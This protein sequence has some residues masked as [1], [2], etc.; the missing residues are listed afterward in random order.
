MIELKNISK[1]FQTPRGTKSVLSDF[2]LTVNDGTF[3]GISGE[4][5]AGKSTL[6]SIIIGLQ[7]PSSG[8]VLID[9][10]DIFSLSDKEL[11]A[12]RNENIGFVSQEQSFLENLTVLEN[13]ALPA[14]LSHKQNLSKSEI[15]LR[16]K[17]LLSDFG[18]SELSEQYPNVLSGG[19]NQ[20]VLIARALMNDP[21][22]IAADEATDA[23]SEKQTKE[24]TSIFKA[25]SSQGKTVIFVSHDKAALENCDEIFMQV[26]KVRQD[27]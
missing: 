8:K 5:G 23:V 13:V 12:F 2:S 25:L 19:E 7:K 15:F 22:I 9:G 21:K 27:F 24:I 18:I 26:S 16:A 20:R 17:K 11:S 1:T 4:S 10:T 3:L 14:L 6:L